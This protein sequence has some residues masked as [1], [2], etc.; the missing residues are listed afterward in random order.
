M[1]DF[2]KVFAPA[3]V[4]NLSCGF[5]ILGLAIQ[6]PGDII[7]AKRNPKTDSLQISKI[8]GDAGKLPTN[9][10]SNT[11]GYAAFKLLES[12]DLQNIGIDLEIHKR[13]PFGSGLG[14]SAAS[15]VGAV[16]AIKELLDL[17]LEKKDLLPFAALGEQRADGAYHL[18]NVAPSLLGG[19][20]LIRDNQSA[21]VINL[22][23]P[24]DLFINVI[25]PNVKILTEEAR[26]V[27][28]D[29]VSLKNHILQSGNLGA[30]VSALYNHDYALLSRCIQDYIVEPQR[31]Q[32]IPGFTEL[33]AVLTKQNILGVGISGSGPSI[34]CL[35]HGEEQAQ[36]I[37]RQMSQFYTNRRI[38]NKVYTSKIN[39]KGTIRI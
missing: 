12:W 24:E 13:M 17:N 6:S 9:I 36:C 4:A 22:P 21:D 7:I 34:F 27:L 28:S 15:A 3:S 39:Q 25:H 35:N 11:A 38:K 18:D 19:I 37:H 1:K 14:S 33:K 26:D 31:Q 23:I 20:T 10:E 16:F 2:V 32:L 8:T 30:F 5:D 29:K